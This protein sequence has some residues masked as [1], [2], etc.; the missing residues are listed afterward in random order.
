M[1]ASNRTCII[2]ESPDQPKTPMQLCCS[3]RCRA[4][5]GKILWREKQAVR[6]QRNCQRCGTLMPPR[7]RRDGNKLYCGPICKAAPLAVPDVAEGGEPCAHCSRLF[8]KASPRQ[9]YLRRVVPGRS[10]QGKGRAGRRRLGNRSSGVG[11][12]AAP[13]PCRSPVCRLQRGRPRRLRAR[14]HADALCEPG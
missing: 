5:R 14:V 12:I 8:V 13:R 2:C 3:D 9:K 7:T 4:E 11:R 1:Q 10:V 6:H